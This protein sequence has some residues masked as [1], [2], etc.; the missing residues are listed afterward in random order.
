MKK[1]FTFIIY[2]FVVSV[3]SIAFP[4]GYRENFL[5]NKEGYLNFSRFDKEYDFAYKIK[6]FNNVNQFNKVVEFNTQIFSSKRLFFFIDM[7]NFETLGNARKMDFSN[8]FNLSTI[9]FSNNLNL[10]SYRFSVELGTVYKLKKN[11]YIDFNTSFGLRS[12]GLSNL[13][14]PLQNSYG[15][16]QLEINPKL[17]VFVKF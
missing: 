7:K 13:E 9:Y 6:R 17:K 2:F 4:M 8:N 3:L 5:I 10:D 15:N 12:M 14:S 1:R 11:V 16:L